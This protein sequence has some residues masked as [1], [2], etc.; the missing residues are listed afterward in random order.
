MP[1]VCFLTHVV[2]CVRARCEVQWVWGLC[3]INGG[4]DI[5]RAGQNHTYVYAH[6]YGVRTVSLAGIY[7]LYGHIQR[8]YTRFWKTLD[9]CCEMTT[10]AVAHEV[11]TK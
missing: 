9:S 11:I 5:C 3:G 1:C 6:I 4:P 2:V 7:H 10:F 8:T